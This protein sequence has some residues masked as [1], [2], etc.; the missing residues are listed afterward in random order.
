MRRLFSLLTTL[1]S[2]LPA[3]LSAQMIWTCA[4]SS[5]GWS[6]RDCHGV[7]AFH[8][9]VWVVGGWSPTAQFNDVWFSTDG[10]SWTCKTDS[11]P[12]DKRCAFSLVVFHDTMWLMGG[13][14]ELANP[15]I[16]WNDV[17]KSGDGDSWICA[18]ASAPWMIR[19]A[20]TSVVFH[21]SMWVMGGIID[22][23]LNSV[24]DVWSSTDGINWQILTTPLGT[25]ADPTGNN[26]GWGYT[27]KIRPGDWVQEQIDLSQFAGQ[28]LTLRFEYVTDAAVNGEGF[29]L[30]DVSIP[31]IG[32]FSDFEQDNGGWE[33]AGWVRIQNRLPQTF[34]LALITIGDN[35]TVEYIPLSNSTSV[36]LPLHIDQGVSEV[37]LVVSA[38]TRYTRQPATYRLQAEK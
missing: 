33:E 30:D 35:T 27:G 18:T 1:C 5:A 10:D 36:D 12:W 13:R 34:R 21:D 20:H 19:S 2:F 14:D 37:V 29:L 28:I 25:A 32:Y 8:D 15:P 16:C 38:T 3:V 4:D 7:V 22:L 24:D 6:P 11:A 31:E 26:Y 17:W 9:A 23:N